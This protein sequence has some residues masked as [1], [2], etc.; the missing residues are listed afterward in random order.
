MTFA[1]SLAVVALAASASAMPSPPGYSKPPTY[2]APAQPPSYPSQ[3]PAPSPAPAPVPAPAPAPIPKPPSYTVPGY[4]GVNCHDSAINAP[5][6]ETCYTY[7]TEK[8]W[9][10]G[11]TFSPERCIS[12]CEAETKYNA[13]YLNGRA[14]CR[15]V[16]TYMLYKNGVSQGQ[17]CAMYTRAWDASFATNV[18]YSSGSDKFTIATSWSYSNDKDAGDAK[19][20]SF[21][22][23]CMGERGYSC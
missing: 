15:F 22:V 14:T 23:F 12:A 9:N 10:D 11:Q 17:V 2:S 4:T 5:T 6:D 3:S 21:T 7:I 8:T 19:S 18:G 13:D 20:V 16:N 1:L